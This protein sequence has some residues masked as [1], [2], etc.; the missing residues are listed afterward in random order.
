[1]KA[2]IA[3]AATIAATALAVLPM[4]ASAVNPWVYEK[5]LDS[6]TSAIGSEFKRGEITD[7]FHRRL[8]NG[9]HEIYANVRTNSGGE[10]VLQRVTCQTNTSG[11]TVLEMS[12][13]EGRW[14]EGEQNDGRG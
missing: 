3:T 9:R 12:A 5:P 6:C 10:D 2:R 7:T 4:T 13:A 11:R 1:M 8:D 14:V